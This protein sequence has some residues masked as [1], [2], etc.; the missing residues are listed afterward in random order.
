[1]DCSPLG[2]RAED[3]FA[4]FLPLSSG[5]GLPLLPGRSRR[6]RPPGGLPSRKVRT[7][8]GSA[9]R[10]NGGRQGASPAGRKVP[11]KTNRP[12]ALFELRRARVKRWGKSPP[13]QGRPRRQ[14]KPRA[15]QDRT[16]EGRPARPGSPGNSRTPPRRGAPLRRDERNDRHPPPAGTES[17]L[18]GSNFF[19]RGGMSRSTGLQPV[20]KKR[21]GFSAGE[22]WILQESCSGRS[23]QAAS[24]CCIAPSMEK[25][26]ALSRCLPIMPP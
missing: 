2:R 21:K 26:F 3:A 16:G 20:E 8:Q 24:L 17:G 13:R 18:Q 23:P 10:E 1:M 11:Q 5:V 25:G 14:G 4:P 19:F 22:T 7:P 6:G 9:P 12:S 15:V